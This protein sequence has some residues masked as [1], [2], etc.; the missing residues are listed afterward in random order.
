MEVEKGKPVARM[1]KIEI[2][3]LNQNDMK[4]VMSGT[5]VSMANCLRRIMIAEVPILAIDMVDIEENSS[6][7]FDQFLAHRLGLIPIMSKRVHQFSYTRDCNCEDTCEKC[8]IPYEL[9]VTNNNEDGS[10][11]HVTSHDLHLK[12]ED[13]DYN[14]DDSGAPYPVGIHDDHEKVLICKLG[15]NQVCL[16]TKLY[17]HPLVLLIHGT[18]CLSFVRFALCSTHSV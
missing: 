17:C 5:D 11:K 7:L 13:D 15:K 12:L 1:P 18:L 8:S 4:F 14:Y 3:E 9:D 2:L 10:V 16:V 6:C